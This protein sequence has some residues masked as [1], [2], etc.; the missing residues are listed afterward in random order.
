MS[1]PREVVLIAVKLRQ[2]SCR[3]QHYQRVCKVKFLQFI[4]AIFFVA[5][6]SPAY[7]QFIERGSEGPAITI[8]EFKQIAGVGKPDSWVE[9]VVT[10]YKTSG[11]AFILQGSLSEK[12]END[13]YRFLDGTGSIIVEINDFGGVKV[14][15]QD[16]VRLTGEADYRNGKLLLEVNKFQ[17]LK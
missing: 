2:N 17:I 10:A 15:P 12:L 13:R 4:F 7:G 5:N 16:P 9:Q 1:V 11:K 8:R 14:G 6:L 3:G